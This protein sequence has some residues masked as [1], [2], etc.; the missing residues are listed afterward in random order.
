[1]EAVA[2]AIMSFE[3]WYAGSRS[4]RN[5]NPGNLRNTSLPHTL[6]PDQYAVFKEFIGGYNALMRDLRDKFLGYT[7]TGLGPES[8]LLDLFEKYAPADDANAPVI[9]ASFVAQWI[10]RALGEH[11]T[12]ASKLKEIWPEDAVDLS[13]I[14][15]E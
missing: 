10:S 8:T 12:M 5:R 9:Y 7:K 15:E 4:N 11:F 1:M 3:G 2:D 14:Q 6:D 13:G